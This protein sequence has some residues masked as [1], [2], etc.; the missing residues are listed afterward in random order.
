[1]VQSLGAVNVRS[2]SDVTGHSLTTV[3]YGIQIA[4]TS[5]SQGLRDLSGYDDVWG[6]NE[7][8]GFDSD[9]SSRT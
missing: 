9:D 5:G 1:M 7:R 3:Y 8:I 6:T 4:W 2:W